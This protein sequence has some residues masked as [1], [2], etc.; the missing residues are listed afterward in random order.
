MYTATINDDIKQVHA[1]KVTSHK[2]ERPSSII[3]YLPHHRVINI[4]KPERVRVVFDAGAKFEDTC[5]NNN[6]LKR[7]DL[8]NNLLSV[9]LKFREGLYGLMTEDD[10]DESRRSTS[11]KIFLKRQ[12]KS[13]F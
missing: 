8:L 6:I 5:I 11:L 12:S 4:N 2:S 9:L 13:S 10:Q 1:I 3:N 7:P